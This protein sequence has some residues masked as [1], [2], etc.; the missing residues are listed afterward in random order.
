MPLPFFFHPEAD[1]ELIEAASYYGERSLVVGIEFLQ[2]ID[3]AIAWIS[4]MPRA[5]PAWPG[6]PNVR[7]R[8]VPKFPFA[9]VYVVEHAEIRIIAIE[10]AK[11]RPGSWLHRL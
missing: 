4:E 9:I 5:A 1:T 10:H 7:R 11:R 8:V 3:K 6:R 2:V